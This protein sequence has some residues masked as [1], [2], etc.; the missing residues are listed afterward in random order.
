MVLDPWARGIYKGS[1]HAEG[2]RN[3][4][5]RRG[6]SCADDGAN[7][8]GRTTRTRQRPARGEKARAASWKEARGGN[9]TGGPKRRRVVDG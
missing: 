2:E 4:A 6:L 3:G 9:R 8:P 1:D 5:T 7:Q